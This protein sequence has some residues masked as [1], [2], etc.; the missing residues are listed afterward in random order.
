VE[1]G[2]GEGEQDREAVATS[3]AGGIS[4]EVAD[5]DISMIGVMVSVTLAGLAS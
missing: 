5:I 3:G 4:N 1:G 2:G